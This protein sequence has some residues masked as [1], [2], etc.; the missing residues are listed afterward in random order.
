MRGFHFSKSPYL[1]T[2]RK[3]GPLACSLQPIAEDGSDR[4]KCPVLAKSLAMGQNK[5]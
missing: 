4:S 1:K 5:A 2:D 3:I